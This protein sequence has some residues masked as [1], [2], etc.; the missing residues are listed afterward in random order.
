[1]FFF[2]TLYLQKVLGYSALETGVAFL[3]VSAGIVIGSV[4][5]PAADPP[6]RA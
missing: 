2:S 5:R 6:R 4:A 1:M 3:P